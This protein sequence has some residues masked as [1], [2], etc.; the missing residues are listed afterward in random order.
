M[1]YAQGTDAYAERR[2][3]HVEHPPVPAAET[4]AHAKKRHP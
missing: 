1:A 4:D 2:T 3:A